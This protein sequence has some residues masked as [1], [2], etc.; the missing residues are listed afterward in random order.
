MSIQH[1]LISVQNQYSPERVSRMASRPHPLT[2]TGGVDIPGKKR[3]RDRVW[4]LRSCTLNDDTG[5]LPQLC[6]RVI[7]GE[8][9]ENGDALSPSPEVLND[10]DW[11]QKEEGDRLLY[12][13]LFKLQQ[14][15][16]V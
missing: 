9:S 12:L 7:T 15:S 5:S 6:L 11:G 16:N 2:V 13:V 14:D 4:V 1:S 8:L 10:L 3:L